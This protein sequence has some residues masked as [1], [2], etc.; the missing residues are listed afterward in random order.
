MTNHAPDWKLFRTFLEVVREGSLSRAARSLGLTQPTTGRQI[1]TLEEA[2]GVKLF[3]RSPNGLLPTEE[4]VRL[5]A[6]AEIMAAAAEQALRAVS[7][8]LGEERG[9]IRIAASDIIGNE[10]LPAILANFRARHP[11]IGFELT[12]SNQ[13]ENL[14]RGDADIAVRMVRPTQGAI[15]TRQIGR[16][17]V[18]LF[19][20]RRYLDTCSLPRQKRELRDHA[21]IGYDRD[22]SYARMLEWLGEPLAR[23]RFAFCSDSD[24]AQLAALRAGIG[25]G[26]TQLGIARRDPNLVPVL[27][28]QLIYPM[29]VWIAMHSDLRVNRRIRLMFD[30]L[31]DE[32]M[33][34]AQTSRH[35]AG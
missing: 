4:G 11:Q 17:D 7:G 24:S 13:N 21:L 3:V 33:S 1:A 35:A 14:L 30:H 6:S 16:I 23:D 32:L 26:G 29:D 5:S 2:L 8:K 25:I 20:H 19:A 9:T 15:L 27:H 31:A 10:V 18:G 28:D 34:Y 12:L 22:R